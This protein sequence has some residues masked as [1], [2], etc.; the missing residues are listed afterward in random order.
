MKWIGLALSITGIIGCAST[1]PNLQ[2]ASALAIGNITPEAIQV[3]QVQRSVTAVKWQALTPQGTYGCSA[4]D[5][6]RR[7]LCVKGE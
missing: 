6:V 1:T 5:M 2:R 3:A 7:P 4:D